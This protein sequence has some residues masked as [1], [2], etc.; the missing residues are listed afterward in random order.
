MA[1]LTLFASSGMKRGHE[2]QT[3]MEDWISPFDLRLMIANRIIDRSWRE[4]KTHW[5][6]QDVGKLLIELLLEAEPELW[7]DLQSVQSL[8]ALKR[9]LVYAYLGAQDAIPEEHRDF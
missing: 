5:N 9:L 7:R 1:H 6:R 8:L 2:K 4:H 3:V